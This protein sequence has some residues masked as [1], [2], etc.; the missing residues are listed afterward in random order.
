MLNSLK[1]G[2]DG[3][4]GSSLIRQPKGPG[5]LLTKLW[6]QKARSESLQWPFGCLQVPEIMIELLIL[7]HVPP[8]P[9]MSC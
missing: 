7:L 1:A 2:G 4:N 8:P 5:F 3:E 6:V 9:D